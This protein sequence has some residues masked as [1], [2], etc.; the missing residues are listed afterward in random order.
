MKLFAPTTLCLLTTCLLAGPPESRTED[1]R[2]LPVTSPTP[3]SAPWSIL[4]AWTANHPDWTDTI[5]IAG[6]GTFSRTQYHDSGHWTLTALADRV[7]LVLAWDNWPAETVTMISPDE[8]S[9]KVRG[10]GQDG[11]LTLHR[12][13]AP[14]A[15]AAP[16]ET[17]T[18]HQGEPPVRLIRKEEAL[19]AHPRDRSFSRRGRIGAGLCRR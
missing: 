14:V 15:N 2:A 12:L 8:F 6:D 18:W 4:G 3:R 11:A 5:T 19:R 13:R 10:A 17:H 1:L 7:V 9:G 16:Y